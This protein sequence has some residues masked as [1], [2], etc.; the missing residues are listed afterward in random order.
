MVRFY[1]GSEVWKDVAPSLFLIIYMT[2][3]M[4][5]LLTAQSSGG[6]GLGKGSTSE[7]V[8]SFLHWVLCRRHSHSCDLWLFPSLTEI[9][10]WNRVWAWNCSFPQKELQPVQDGRTGL[11]RAWGQRPALWTQEQSPNLWSLF[12]FVHPWT[13]EK[14]I[15]GF[16]RLKHTNSTLG[17]N[18]FIAPINCF[19][20][21]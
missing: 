21:L 20:C 11:L 5:G 3:N 1:C 16:C 13:P 6:W 14:Q 19:I 4:I 9:H 18:Y 7:Q 2:D 15:S 8:C 17:G 12:A 10:L